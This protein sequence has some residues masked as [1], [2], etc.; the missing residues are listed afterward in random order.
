M[1]DF[2]TFD[3]FLTTCHLFDILTDDFLLKPPQLVIGLL[4]SR[5]LS[6]FLFSVDQARWLF[7][8]SLVS[9]VIVIPLS[10]FMKSRVQLV[11]FANCIGVPLGA[12]L[13]L[14][15]RV[16]HKFGKNLFD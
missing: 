16:Q 9:A 7:I 15:V 13:G 8:F 11:L 2:L 4:F 5:S 6:I 3:I 10:I 1:F 14:T 12:A